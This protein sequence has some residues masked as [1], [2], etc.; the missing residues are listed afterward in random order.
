MY[1]WDD[2]VNNNEHSDTPPDFGPAGGE[3][4]KF[5]A[6]DDYTLKIK[7]VAPSPADGR[8]SGDVG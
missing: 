6:V 1:W 8:S 5:I 2:L 3:A 7:Y 4:A